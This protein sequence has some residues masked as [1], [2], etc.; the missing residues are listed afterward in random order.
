[1]NH[2]F[3]ISRLEHL[4]LWNSSLSEIRWEHKDI[5]PIWTL[6]VRGPSYLG[7]TRSI[8]WLLM[9]CL[10]TSPVHQQPW[11]W[12]YR[13][14]RS[15][16]YLSKCFKYLC[17]INVEEWLKCKYMFIFPQKNLARKGLRTMWMTDFNVELGAR[18]LTN[19]QNHLGPK[20]LNVGRIHWFYLSRISFRTQHVT[21]EQTWYINPRAYFTG[22][23]Y[24]VIRV[25]SMSSK[26]LTLGSNSWLAK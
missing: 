19:Y 15:F 18:T 7:L 5:L 26:G 21:R 2:K 16:S 24:R 9:P 13:I 10:L 11:Y 17:Q 1:M 12:L 14:C 25:Y 3:A 6:S 20:K 22:D 8:S 4:H 23:Q